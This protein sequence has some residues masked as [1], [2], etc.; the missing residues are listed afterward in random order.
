[1]NGWGFVA[2]GYV[3]SQGVDLAFCVQLSTPIAFAASFTAN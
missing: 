2:V 3:L 1:M